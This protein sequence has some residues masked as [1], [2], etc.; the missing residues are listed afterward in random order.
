MRTLILQLQYNGTSYQ[1]WQRQKNTN[2]T[3]EHQLRQAISKIT[4]HLTPVELHCAGRTDKGVHAVGQ[5]ISMPLQSYDKRAPYKWK[6]GLN[7]F[8]SKDIRIVDATI[9]E[10]PFHA[11]FDANSREYIYIFN[12]KPSLFLEDL[13]TPLKGELDLL[14]LNDTTRVILGQHNFQSFQGGSC[15]A[16]SPVKT[17]LDASWS[18]QGP[19]LI[20]YVKACGFLHHMVRYL[21]ACQLE[22]AQGHHSLPWFQ[23]LLDDKV[24]HHYCASAKGLYFLA[25]NY[26]DSTDIPF[27]TRHPFV[28]IKA[29]VKT[30]KA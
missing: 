19:L 15:Q 29:L 18:K 1:G 7:H 28:D 26:S 2:L 20:F 23:S 11:R 27:E 22:V 4:P 10:K 21:V 9:V 16:K 30:P 3:I 17:I 25:A 24:S 8:L 13:T 6:E 5:I 12:T 14:A